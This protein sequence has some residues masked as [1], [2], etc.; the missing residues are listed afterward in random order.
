MHASLGGNSEALLIPCVCPWGWPSSVPGYASYPKALL[1]HCCALTQDCTAESSAMALALQLSVLALRKNVSMGLVLLTS[2]QLKSWIGNH[3]TTQD[4]VVEMWWFFSWSKSESSLTS[5]K[6]ICSAWG[7]R[8]S[9][10][11]I[12]LLSSLIS[13]RCLSSLLH[14]SVSFTSPP[15]SCVPRPLIFSFLKGCSSSVLGVEASEAS[16]KETAG[17]QATEATTELCVEPWD[18]PQEAFTARVFLS[19]VAIGGWEHVWAPW[20]CYEALLG[21]TQKHNLS[22]CL[23][24]DMGQEAIG[25]HSCLPWAMYLL[26]AIAASHQGCLLQRMKRPIT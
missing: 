20:S 23:T 11:V 17:S 1:V 18:G 26:W 5:Q 2:F 21:G 9:T 15:L 16:Q 13:P 25:A 19:G 24:W 8:P 22:L 12:P 10:A 7:E 14:F 4:C 6:N 3:C